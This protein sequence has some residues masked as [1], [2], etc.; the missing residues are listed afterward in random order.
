MEKVLR[1]LNAVPG[2]IGSMILDE[3]GHLLVHAFPVSFD[4]DTFSQA[5]SLLVDSLPVMQSYLSGIDLLDIRCKNG[6]IIIKPL[7]VGYLVLL[8]TSEVNLQLLNISLNVAVAKLDKMM[9]AAPDALKEPSNVMAAAIPLPPPVVVP[10]EDLQL[11]AKLQGMQSALAKILGPMATIIFQ[12]CL[13]KWR[14]EAPQSAANLPG[15]LMIIQQEIN[16]REKATRY[17]DMISHYL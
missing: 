11:Q 17:K 2:M 9:G 13:E 8:S 10:R 15:L 16:D 4:P 12:E 5:G 7:K 3:N 14:Q 6:R 1:Q